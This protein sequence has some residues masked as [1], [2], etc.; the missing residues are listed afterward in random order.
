MVR[1]HFRHRRDW[2]RRFGEDPRFVRLRSVAE[3]R[4]W[5]EGQGR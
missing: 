1:G 2:P 4:D 3:A 5:L